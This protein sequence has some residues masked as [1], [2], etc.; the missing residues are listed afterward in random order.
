MTVRLPSVVGHRGAAASAPENTL[1]GL[2]RALALGVRCVE[3]DVKLTADGVAILMH[4]D[5]LDRTTDGKGRVAATT[6]AAIR[7]LDAGAWFAPEF[8]GERVPGFEA[9]IDLLLETGLDANVEIKP[10]AGR[11]TETGAAVARILAAR[12]PRDRAPPLLSSFAEASLVA[13]RAA[14]PALPRGLLVKHVPADWRAR[15]DRL[16]CATFHC[17]HREL[18]AA[19][20]AAVRG[21]GFPMLVYTVNEA[22][23]ARTLFGWG[24]DCICSDRP[25]AILAVAP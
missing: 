14:A 22:E 9:A 3:F 12:W 8:A 20:V 16:D 11:E 17:S 10:C 23:R 25:E 7:S 2:R 13:A 15:L 5:T 1:A 24:V 18:D 4:D 19:T 21:A 6:A